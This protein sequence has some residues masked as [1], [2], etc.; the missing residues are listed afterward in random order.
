[1]NREVVLS[2]YRDI[3]KAARTWEDAKEKVR[4]SQQQREIPRPFVAKTAFHQVYILE[5][6]KTQ[7]RANKVRLWNFTP[8]ASDPLERAT[9]LL[10]PCGSTGAKDQSV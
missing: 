10:G 5:E 1:M 6:T 4:V 9:L 7:F 2:L 8:L 3:L